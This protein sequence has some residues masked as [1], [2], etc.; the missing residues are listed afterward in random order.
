MIDNPLYARPLG[1]PDTFR[2]LAVRPHPRL[3]PPGT[4]PRVDGIEI[5]NPDAIEPEPPLQT[6]T[7]PDPRTAVRGRK[8]SAEP[9]ATAGTIL[10]LLKKTPGG[11]CT[12]EI[13]KRLHA[14]GFGSI[15]RQCINHHINRLIGLGRVC[16]IRRPGSG[17]WGDRPRCKNVFIARR[18]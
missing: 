10:T 1:A 7:G 8:K 9:S 4:R 11:L 18:N 5:R 16:A 3:D 6:E 12:A 17:D 2:P 13:Y 15:S 14:V